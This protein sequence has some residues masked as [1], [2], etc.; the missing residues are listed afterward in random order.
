M[1][2]EYVVVKQGIE[3]VKGK[4]KVI[5]DRPTPKFMTKVRSF[6]GLANSYKHIIKDFST[7]VVPL[8]EIV[9][10]SVGFKWDDE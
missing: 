3:M 4:V 6:H 8:I 2:L 1:F 7:L 10:K 9:K 5:W